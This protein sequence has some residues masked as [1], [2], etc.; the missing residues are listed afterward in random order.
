[1]TLS[2]QTTHLSKCYDAFTLH[3]VN[4]TVSNGN[5][6]GLVGENG[7]G[8]TT[9]IKLLLNAIKPSD[10]SAIVLGHDMAHNGVA[11][12]REI[13][14]VFEDCFFHQKLTSLEIAWFVSSIY[15][16]WFSD[17]FTKLLKFLDIDPGKKVQ[18][19]S[20][21]M[22]TKLSLAIAMAHSPK[23]LILDEITSGLDPVIRSEVLELIRGYVDAD[24]TRAALFSTHITSDLE[25]IADDLILLNH[26][27]VTFQSPVK[28]FLQKHPKMTLDDIVLSEIKRVRQ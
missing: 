18:D 15:P 2:I 10:G 26:G 11:A 6:T 4:I 3:D 25:K 23:L 20:K 5:I 19:L 27:A 14:V 12:K 21:G 16:K 28:N 8:K 7:A 9:L 17:T 13:G 24:K 22:K 1:M